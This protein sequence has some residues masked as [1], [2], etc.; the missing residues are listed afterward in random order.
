[1][2]QNSELR[3]EARNVLSG[4]W[5]MAALA[6]F[7]YSAITGAAGSIPVAGAAVCLLTL[8]IAY[9]FTVLF[10]KVF[11]GGEVNIGSL[12]DGFQDYG[13]ILGTVL[14]QTIYTILWM[15]LLI[16]P[17]IV[18]GY[19]YAMTCYI[20]LDEPE[21]KHNAAI[22]R[23]MAMMNGYKMKLFLLDLSFIGWGLLAILTFGIGMFWLQPY[24]S[25]AHAAFYEDLKSNA[26]VA[27]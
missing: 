20:L 18:K 15:L 27:A 12:F 23:S 13:R 10:L 16:V 5:I 2:K 8:P 19:S 22:E 17:G 9:G 4:N 7:V 11:R 26:Q 1:M 21:L 14:L 24:M 25:T 6:A 3:Q